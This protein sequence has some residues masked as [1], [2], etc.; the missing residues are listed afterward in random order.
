MDHGTG[1]T[2][3]SCPCEPGDARKQDK[4]NIP[5]TGWVPTRL[6]KKGGKPIQLG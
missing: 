6:I 2:V 1:A 3:R 4:A 5:G